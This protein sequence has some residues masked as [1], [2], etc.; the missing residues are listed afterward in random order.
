MDVKWRHLTTDPS[1]TRASLA[2]LLAAC[3][4]SSRGQHHWVNFSPFDTFRTRCGG[5][6][7]VGR[8]S[9]WRCTDVLV[10]LTPRYVVCSHSHT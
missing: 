1:S 3:E 5:P 4:L 10:C 8:A 9:C 2:V 7:I 6:V